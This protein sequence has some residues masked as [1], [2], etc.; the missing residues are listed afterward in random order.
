[1]AHRQASYQAYIYNAVGEISYLLVETPMLSTVPTYKYATI[2]ATG[3]IESGSTYALTD[4]KWAINNGALA[5]NVSDAQ[6]N[7]V[8]FTVNGAGTM[9]DADTKWGSG[10]QWSDIDAAN[11]NTLFTYAHDNIES[12]EE[13]HL[14]VYQLDHGPKHLKII[15]HNFSQN[16]TMDQIINSGQD[17]KMYYSDTSEYVNETNKFTYGYTSSNGN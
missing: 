8:G 5:H 13:V 12:V 6:I 10:Y 2:I 9:N 16:P 15:L 4:F 11:D 1:L 7:S 17:F 3:E 14:Y